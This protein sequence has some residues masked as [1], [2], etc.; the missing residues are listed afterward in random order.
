MYVGQGQMMIIIIIVSIVG[1]FF[2]TCLAP[3]E[4]FILAITNVYNRVVVSVHLGEA[5]K[6]RSHCKQNNNIPFNTHR[7]CCPQHSLGY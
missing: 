1:Q 7:L 3:D 4:L 6:V 5:N 2:K